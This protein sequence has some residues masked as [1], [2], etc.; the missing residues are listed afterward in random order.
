[1]NELFTPWA[2]KI[3]T[4]EYP[5][6]QMVRQSYQPLDGKW[7]YLI[8]Q[9]DLTFIP[10][11]NTQF[12]GE[13]LVPFSPESSLSG[14]GRTLLPDEVLVYRTTFSRKEDKARA[15]LHFGAVD[16]ECRVYVNGYLAGMHTGGYTPFEC[17][18]SQFIE[19]ENTLCV[20][21]VDPTDTRPISRGK[22][23]TEHGGIWYTP[24]SGIWQ[25]VWIEYVPKT[26]I[27]FV[28][29][30]PDIDKKSV[31]INLYTNAG[32]KPFSAT[33][34]GK[35]YNSEG[36]E[37]TIQIDDVKLWSP[38][39]PY[40]YDIELKSGED[41]V[42]SY[43]A[44][45]KFSVGTRED[46]KP[47]F[48]LNNSPYFMTGL[49]DQGY[50]SDGL[51]TAPSD[52]ALQYDIKLAKECGFNT[53]RKH[54]KVEPLRWYYHCDRLGMIV[55]QDFINGGGKYN[56]LAILILPNLGIRV[57]DSHYGFYARKDKLGR[58]L[59]YKEMDEIIATL[60][61]TP[62]LGL[63]TVFNEGWGQ[64]DSKNVTDY[65][66]VRDKTRIIDSTSGWSDQGGKIKSI[67]KYFVPFKM[68]KREKRPVSLSEYGGYSMKE[69]GHSFSDK[70]FGYAKFNDAKSLN[71]AIKKLW[72][73]EI[74]PARKQGL[75]AAIYTQL[76]D[77][78]EEV[79][80]IV[81]YDRQ[82]VK[83]DK[84]LMKSLNEKL[85]GK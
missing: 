68:P 67:H 47:C 14:V 8:R 51:Y 70:I 25:S 41:S 4:S 48:M 66:K 77:V 60:Y 50:W 23:K 72:T 80:G 16:Y 18:L 31:K 85:C 1:M 45:R 63:W 62:S 75:C 24:T 30:T 83:V 5:R 13:I 57:K 11:E 58:D 43:F 73:K 32:K 34:D 33:V 9:G 6:P 81:T 56:P 42:K 39:I 36:D 54:I 27:R 84:D 74:I 55:W 20:C 38:E 49:L 12:D 28:Y 78:Q 64:F 29:F 21:V 69:E 2:D 3:N 40:L 53:L 35:T 82:V 26:Y 7:Q 61:N 76:S 79:N 22:Q 37:L 59:Y 19:D 52:E 17:D 46:G 10:D 65:L 71:D 44:M 15:I